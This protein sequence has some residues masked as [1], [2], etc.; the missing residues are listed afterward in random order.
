MTKEIKRERKQGTAISR[1]DLKREA[2]AAEAEPSRV[3]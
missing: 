3:A 1:F 2:S